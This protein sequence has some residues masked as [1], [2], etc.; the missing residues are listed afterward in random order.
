MTTS[1]DTRA[2]LSLSH[3][4]WSCRSRRRCN[5][6]W[7]RRKPFGPQ[8]RPPSSSL[9]RDPDRVPF[10]SQ[11]GGIMSEA[12]IVDAIRTPIGRAIKGTLRD[13]RADDLAAIPL[14]A[15]VDRNPGVDFSETDDI[16]M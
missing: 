8:D 10:R 11:V 14:R 13:I 16:M 6:P 3:R 12:V 2:G 1:G 4:A 5:A 9:G 15:L 7:A